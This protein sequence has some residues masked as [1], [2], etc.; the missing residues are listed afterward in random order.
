MKPSSS[1]QVPAA[2]AAIALLSLWSIFGFYSATEEAVGPNAD[3]YKIGE[4]P[5][6][7]QD[8]VS[9]LPATGMIGY[10]SDVP[11]SQT[12]GEVLYLGAEYTLAPRLVTDRRL[13]TSAGWVIGDFSKPLNVVQFG[14]ARGL[15][16]VKDFGNGVVLYR[17]QTR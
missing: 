7:F 15:T 3:V 6:R 13:K 12:L 2:C 5:A 16:M 4:Q 1:W 14:K 8:L 11:F 9:A 10:V 17:N